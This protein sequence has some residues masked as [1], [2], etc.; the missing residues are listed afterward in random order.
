MN[1]RNLTDGR[2]STGCTFET[3]VREASATQTGAAVISGQLRMGA[4]NL[5]S[6]FPVASISFLAGTTA[7][8]AGSSIH[9]WVALYNSSLGLL[10][11]STDNTSG[12]VW[13]Q[14]ALLTTALS[15][16]YTTTYAGLHYL[17]LM[18]SQT[19]GTFPTHVATGVAAGLGT[20]AVEVPILAGNSSSASLTATAPDPAGAITAIANT[21]IYGGVA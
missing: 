18:L 11:Q 16:S 3:Y 7:Y 12:P 6:G 5:P 8:V 13:G 9:F 1:D 14:G 4:I 17:G 21:W 2:R 19:G 10:R 15:S 20:I